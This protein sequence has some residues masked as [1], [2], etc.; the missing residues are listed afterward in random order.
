M[1]VSDGL[2]RFGDNRSTRFLI[3]IMVG[4]YFFI[5]AFVVLGLYCIAYGIKRLRRLD[6]KNAGYV[7]SRTKELKNIAGGALLIFI[8]VMI[9]FVRI[10]HPW[11]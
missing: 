1:G 2:H 8:G 3:N 9:Y 5:G 11:R 10:L 4:Y 7:E 6:R